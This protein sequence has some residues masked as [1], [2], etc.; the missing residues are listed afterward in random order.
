MNRAMAGGGPAWPK[1]VGWY[2]EHHPRLSGSLIGLCGNLHLADEVADEAF[3]RAWLHWGRIRAMDRPA[4]W[5]YRTAVNELRRRQR[6][7][8]CCRREPVRSSV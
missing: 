3:A 8:V 2:E 6:Q 5:L 4:G 7:A 1:F